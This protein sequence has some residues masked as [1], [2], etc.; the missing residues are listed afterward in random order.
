MNGK[1]ESQIG[2]LVSRMEVGRKDDRENLKEIMEDLM[3]NI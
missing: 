2:S 1:M 3:Q